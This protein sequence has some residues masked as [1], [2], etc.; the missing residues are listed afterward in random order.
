MSSDPAP[1]KVKSAI[2]AM[3]YDRAPEATPIFPL[4]IQAPLAFVM[5]L[6]AAISGGLYYST[7]SF[8]K[9]VTYAASTSIALSF[10]AIFLVDAVRVYTG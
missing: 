2:A 4:G 6:L 10:G 1:Y 5:L 7:G 3:V 9:S 8:T